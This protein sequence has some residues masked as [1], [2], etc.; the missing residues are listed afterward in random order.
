[1]IEQSVI[2][3]DFI[4]R[5]FEAIQKITH[6]DKDAK[7]FDFILD[8][9]YKEKMSYEICKNYCAILCCNYRLVE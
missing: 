1:M 6:T 4:H 2:K 8:G 9:P 5:A 7:E 3:S